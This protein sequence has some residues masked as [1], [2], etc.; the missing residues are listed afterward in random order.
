V[1]STMPSA[2]ATIQ[3]DSGE[4]V[5]ILGGDV[6]GHCERKNSYEH[7]ANSE[8]LPR[9]SCLSLQTKKHCEW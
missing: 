6:I 8:C 1:C 2:P 5:N 3:G 9:Y 4:N 7:V